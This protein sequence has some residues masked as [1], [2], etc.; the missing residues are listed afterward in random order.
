MLTAERIR[1]GRR[2][3]SAIFRLVAPSLLALAFLLQNYVAERHFHPIVTSSATH[4]RSG[5]SVDFVA[6]P[7]VPASDQQQD[8][9]CPLCQ[10]LGLGATT[11]VPQVAVLPFEPVEAIA[12]VGFAQSEAAPLAHFSS[13][14][15][16]RGPP[17]PFSRT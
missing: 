1:W 16:P 11:D 8:D 5:T 4:V 12:L 17:S 3:L 9:D 2:S 13:S 7:F 10:V 15:S 14:H 6:K